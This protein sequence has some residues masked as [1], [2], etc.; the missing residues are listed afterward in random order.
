M[1]IYNLLEDSDNYSKTSGSW[2][3]YYRDEINDSAIE[4]DYDGNKINN[5]NTITTKYFEYKTQIVGSTPND[6]NTLTADVVVPLKYLSN[7]WKFLDL[8]LINCEI[9][10]DL[11][12][13]KECIV[14]EISITPGIIA[15]PDANPPVQEVAAMQIT[16]QHFK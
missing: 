5:D 8:L 15:N 13:S 6:N 10:L 14:F 3:N 16:E 9:E 12:W 11:S 7:L 2:Q 4:I 1:P